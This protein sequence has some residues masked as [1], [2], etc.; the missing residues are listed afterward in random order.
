MAL[1]SFTDLLSFTIFRGD[2]RVV[3]FHGRYYIHLLRTSYGKNA[4]RV[5]RHCRKP[6]GT[7]QLKLFIISPI[8]SGETWR[9][10]VREYDTDNG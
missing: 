5:L 3:W 7:N 9:E 8:R 6:R 1:T 2:K 10:K 4:A